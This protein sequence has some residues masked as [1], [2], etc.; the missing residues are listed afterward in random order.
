MENIFQNCWF[1]VDKLRIVWYNITMRNKMTKIEQW[2]KSKKAERGMW[3]ASR[4]WH[5]NRMIDAH[6]RKDQHDIDRHEL[7]IREC[8]LKLWQIKP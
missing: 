8:E 2:K 1:E 4:D 3:A 5:L 6:E 7:A